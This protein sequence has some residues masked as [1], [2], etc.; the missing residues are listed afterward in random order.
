MQAAVKAADFILKEMRGEN[1][2]LYHRYAKGERAIEGFL[3]DYAF[4]VWGLVEIYEAGF[5]EAYLQAAVEL[6]K[7]MISRF[8]DE[9]D[10]GFYFTAKDAEHVMPRRK[11]VYDG[12]LPSGNSV[13]LL[14]LT[15][16]ALLTGGPAYADMASQI[17]KVFS[18]EVQRSPAAH[19]FLLVG[20]D[21]VVGTA[22]N[23]I[24]VGNQQEP[25]MQSMLDALKAVYL[26]N[27]VVS[28]R[29][30]GKAGLGYEKLEGKA[31]AYVCRGQTCM[32]PTNEK[33]KMLELLGL[34]Q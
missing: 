15:Q 14:N 1:G 6:T 29:K 20:L 10:G 16:L 4:L 11:Q 30:P 22:Y 8:W 27:V 25:D 18:E 34:K 19:T 23:V 21:L 3:D 31:T 28:M 17:L 32:P 7:A 26:P 13:A 24:L 9:K 5:E 12:A 2:T 33:K